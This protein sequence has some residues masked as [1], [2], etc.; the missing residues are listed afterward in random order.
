MHAPKSTP[1]TSRQ[2][3]DIGDVYR[4]YEYGESDDV[5]VVGRLQKHYK[6]WRDVLHAPPFVQNMVENGYIIPF[7]SPPTKYY[8]K[9]NKSSLNHKEFVESAITDLLKKGAIQEVNEQPYCCN[10]LTVAENNS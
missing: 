2:D 3:H 7:N 1:Q 5:S 4:N 9:N 8:A 10:P 6:F